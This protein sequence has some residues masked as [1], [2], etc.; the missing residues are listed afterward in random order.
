MRSLPLLAAGL[1]VS[2]AA[3]T[4][5]ASV[6]EAQQR[7]PLRV[8]VQKRSFFDAGKVVPVGTMNRYATIN[9][10]SSP[11]YS[12]TAELYGESTLPPRIGGGSNP[13]ANTIWTP[14]R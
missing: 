2:F 13:F 14:G 9:A 10:V 8:T 3:M 5:A 4:L 6:A 7:R 1:A 11:V 12:N